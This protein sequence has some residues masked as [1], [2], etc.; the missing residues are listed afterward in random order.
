MKKKKENIDYLLQRNASEQLASIDWDKL[1]TAISQR[2]NNAGRSRIPAVR[3]R[4]LFKV[5]AGFAAAAAIVVVVIMLSTETPK[6]VQP[7]SDGKATVSLIDNKGSASV[8]F[9]RKEFAAAVVEIGGLIKQK[10]IAR[11]DIEII[12]ANRD[13]KKRDDRATWMII[14]VPEP[15]LA[16]NG[17]SRDQADLACLL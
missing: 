15:V 9:K 4:V 13:M 5:A 10:N 8:E 7:V 3:Y 17:I 11:C 2:L 1:N 14:R 16:D 6:N 12:N